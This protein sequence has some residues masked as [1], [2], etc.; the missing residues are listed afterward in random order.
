M[1]VAIN[2][3]GRIGRLVFKRALEKGVNVVAIN[4]MMDPETLS[5]LL[6]NDSVYGKYSKKVEARDDSIIVGGKKIL[7]F[8]EKEPEK[9]PWK[10]LEVDVV[11]ES[12]GIFKDKESASKHLTAGAKKVL[13]SAPSKDCDNVIVLGV[14]EKSLKKSDKIIS[15]ASCTTNC[16][17]PIVKILHDKFEITNG[18]LTTIH[19]YTGDQK[20][21]DAP[22]KDPR[23]ARA[24]AI[25]LVPTKSGAATA[26]TQVIPSLKGKLDGMA[27]RAPI[28]CASITDLVVTV[29]KNVTPETVNKAIKDAAKKMPEVLE[30]SEDDL[31][32]TDIVGNTHSS[33]F[34]SKLT[35]T[36]KNMIKIL[37]WYDNEYGYSCRMVDFLKLLK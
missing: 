22:H 37:S 30:Y 4:D 25:N 15:M 9:L 19:A 24:A 18:Y 23:R 28:P 1:R 32:S 33:I 10:K 20:L 35:K 34:D 31:V 13:I 14:N 26:T 16:I 6:K 5:R 7:I 21:V 29:K 27:V 2:G 36:S 11:I 3:F 8:S 17:A 12:T